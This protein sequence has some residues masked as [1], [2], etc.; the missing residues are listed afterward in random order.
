MRLRISHKLGAG[1]VARG[2]LLLACGVAALRGLSRTGDA[3]EELS[4]P[5]WENADAMMMAKIELER[6]MIEVGH[7]GLDLDQGLARQDLAAAREEGRVQ[8]ARVIGAGVFSADQ[9][10]SL[11]AGIHEFEQATDRVVALLDG[12]RP[13]AEV[14]TAQM[15]YAHQCRSLLE[16]LTALEEL[17]DRNFD[18]VSESSLAVQESSRTIVISSLL[19][20]A[21]LGA[22]LGVL[23]VRAVVGPVKVMIDRLR[24]L[25]EGDADLA[26]RLPVVGND[27]VA[28]QAELFNAF[29]GSLD[30]V[31]SV[32][33]HGTSQMS[34]AA[35]SVRVTSEDLAGEAA[36]QAS[37]LEEVSAVLSS[38]SGHAQENVQRAGEA[39]SAMD[40]A[41]GAS[42]DGLGHV[43]GMAGAMSEIEQS[44]EEISKVVKVIDDFAFQTTCS[45]LNAASKPR[46]RG[47]RARDSPSSRRRSGASP[48]RAPRLPRRPNA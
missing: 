21:I 37:A 6:Q 19:V 15:E 32:A 45:A 28:E 40:A 9:L 1:F 14:R 24:A 36:N 17:G 30:E 46:G 27:E 34:Q 25:G 3:L 20:A 33:V 31:M 23:S 48:N 35:D 4:G 10:R 43:E 22:I 5:A 18:R 38:M 13:E 41:V 42:E 44:S 16:S 2:L 7:L 11:E 26:A 8:V 47:K 29:L 12:G 39:I